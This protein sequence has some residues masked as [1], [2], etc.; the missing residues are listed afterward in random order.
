MARRAHRVCTVCFINEKKG[1]TSRRCQKTHRPLEWTPMMC[2]FGPQIW[3][4]LRAPWP[5]RDPAAE[6]SGIS[7]AVAKGR[8]ANASTF[9]GST[10]SGHELWC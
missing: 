6:L 3:K 7:S 1:A 10:A 8:A 9:S 5:G 2:M 4:A